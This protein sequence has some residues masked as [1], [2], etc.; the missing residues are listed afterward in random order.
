M[1]TRVGSGMR[2]PSWNKSQ[3]IQQVISLKAL[4]EPCDD[5]GA[6][7]LRKVVVSP[8]VSF[9]LIIFLVGLFLTQTSVRLLRKK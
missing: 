3:A 5:S 2:R 9:G 4:L 7:A 6:G 1:L 8:R